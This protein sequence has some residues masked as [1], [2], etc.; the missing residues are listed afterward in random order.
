M[1]GDIIRGKREKG[2]EAKRERVDFSTK[3]W[4][5]FRPFQ[6]TPLIPLP[7]K[8]S[9]I[10]SCRFVLR[11]GPDGVV[12]AGGH[13]DQAALA[14]FVVDLGVAF[15]VDADSAVRAQGAANPG[16]AMATLVVDD[17]AHSAPQAG[18]HFLAGG[19]S[20]DGRSRGPGI[21]KG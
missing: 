10:P 15:G 5:P 18:G 17:R 7:Q 1:A 16:A 13:A 4:I 8:L 19:R 12:W 3:P 2:E 9:L 6:F 11:G 20:V 21:L 14:V